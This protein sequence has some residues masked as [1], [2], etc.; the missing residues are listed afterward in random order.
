MNQLNYH[1]RAIH[2]LAVGFSE[3]FRMYVLDSEKYN[4]I[5]M[6]L[7]DEFVHKN[8]PIVNEDD[9][10]DMSAELVFKYHSK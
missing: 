6:E 8:I 7:A 3:E 1:D 5:M 2:L 4:E 9:Q 10:A